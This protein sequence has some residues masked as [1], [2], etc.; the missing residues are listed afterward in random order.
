M[1]RMRGKIQPVQRERSRWAECA[2]AA[3]GAPAYRVAMGF[4]FSRRITIGPGVRLNVS[5][6]GVSTSVGRKGA[7]LRPGSKGTRSTVVWLPGTGMSYFRSGTS[8]GEAVMLVLVGFSLFWLF[9]LAF[10]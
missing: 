6:S 9:W 10:L 8:G 5:K 1:R 2:F 4:R 3:V 7:W